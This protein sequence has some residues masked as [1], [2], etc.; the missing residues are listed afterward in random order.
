MTQPIPAPTSVSKSAKR[1][2][3]GAMGGL[4]VCAIYLFYPQATLFLNKSEIGKTTLFWIQL[5]ML[6]SSIIAIIIVFSLFAEVNPG[7]KLKKV[8]FR[9]VEVEFGEKT[10][11]RLQEDENDTDST[12]AAG[13]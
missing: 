12:T 4:A 8:K 1:V 11:I 2:F 9:G 6:L 5:G 13:S 7:F 10:E 3:W